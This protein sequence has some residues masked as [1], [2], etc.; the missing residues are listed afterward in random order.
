METIMRAF[1]D[2]V[3]SF[4]SSS[5]LKDCGENA[6]IFFQ[7]FPL[8]FYNAVNEYGI[9]HFS[10]EWDGKYPDAREH[11]GA[12]LLPLFINSAGRRWGFYEDLI[13]LAEIL[14][15][16]S[17]FKGEIIIVKNDLFDEYYPI[18]LCF[19]RQTLIYSIENESL[20]Q[21]DL[22][23]LHFYSDC[24][25]EGNCLMVSYVNR[26]F[27]VDIGVNTTEI[28]FY[29]C[30]SEMISVSDE[31]MVGT[32]ELAISV[33]PEIKCALQAGEIR[34]KNYNILCDDSGSIRKN[35]RILNIFGAY[36]G[37][38]FSIA[39][40]TKKDGETSSE[41]LGILKKYWGKDADFRFC[42]FY[43]NPATSCDTVSIS[44]GTI[45]TDIVNQCKNAMSGSDSHYS[46]II[47]TAPT[48]AGKSIFFQLPAIYLHEQSAINAV[49][50]V[51]CPL[52]ALM[53]DQVKELNER[54]INY[55]TYI[56]SALTYEERQSRLEGIKAG[57][58]SI[59]YL[60]P[61][62][63]LAYDIRSLIGDRRIGLMAI[64][65]AHLVTSWGRDFRVD[66]WFLGDYIEKIRKGSF[67][68]RQT[69]VSF[70]VLCLTATAVFGGRDDIIGDLQNSLHLTCYSEHMYIGY[71][72]R[73]N[74]QFVIRHPV[75]ERKSD[76]EEKLHMTSSAICKYVDGKK[77][78]IVYFPYKSQIEDVRTK[79]MSEHPAVLSKTE[80]YYSGE[81]KSLEK[82]EAYSNFRKTKSFVMM[83][84]KAFGMG[85]N[86][87]DV[88]NVYHYA[89]T[90][91]LADYVQ[92]IGRAA[93]QL[94]TG[95]A[96]IDYLKSDMRYAQTLWGL[97]G[98]RHYQIKAMMKK[99]YAL[100]TE[101][102]HRNMLFSPET[103]SF[104]FDVQSV[105]LKVKSGL[106]LLSS[107]LLEKY[108]FKVITVRAK[109]LFSKQY[110]VVPYSIE[111]AFL[112]KYGKYCERMNDCRKQV[113]LAHGYKA[114]MTITKT[115]DV[116]EI[117][118][119]QLWE[120]EFIDLT[121]AQF[122][123]KFFSGELFSVDKSDDTDIIVPNMKLIITYDKGYDEIS[124]SFMALA[125]AIQDTFSDIKRS[126]GGRAF[127]SNDFV[128][129]FK[130]R[131]TKEIRREYILMLLELFCY[132]HVDVYDLPSEPW[133][134]VERRKMET[135]R[136]IE[137]TAFF[138]R[139]QKYAYIAQNLRR[140]FKQAAPNSED[141]KKYIAYISL[142]KNGV[143]PSYQQLM[144][145]V[146]QLFD[147]A[148]YEFVGGRNPQIFVRIN[149][150]IKLRRLAES[151][152]E[153]RNSV[154]SDI[155]ARHKRAVQIM[156]H[157]MGADY[158]NEER[159]HIIENY[160]LGND[161]LVDE[162]LGINPSL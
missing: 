52:V 22:K 129:R 122:K 91:T 126:F 130:K 121:F 100:Y 85:V 143:A 101:K 51:V 116:Y 27:S 93:R 37:V 137:D 64:D 30:I 88:V 15:D 67:Y 43:K 54:G 69:E 102:R 94:E 118:L 108:H 31:K 89:P 99:L 76:K 84:T 141:G 114:E 111:K 106:M 60:S 1:S 157:F 81:M 138:I 42:T 4:F 72:R 50:L 136:Q 32:V 145:S 66:Y 103:F 16:F 58:Y 34:D 120:T 110:I 28:G 74:I 150:P 147:F 158:S 38:H 117:D 87:G 75:R 7:G 80:K 124:D 65:E 26:H 142:P 113:E 105:D 68:S 77:K 109:N 53:V 39:Y 5:R 10:G 140:Y 92:E 162:V 48:G 151:T 133:K 20:N 57:R 70:P 13:A 161:E 115:G 125:S 119:A 23:L 132:D 56:N 46:D 154:L 90:G 41:Y 123:A 156:N 17:V 127:T 148:T 78:T 135:E 12:K 131:Y 71:V 36:F 40:K 86:I 79:L 21:S 61:E 149:D 95:Y 112:S 160:F 11:S 107:D 25:I 139:T 159:W 44:Q 45:I 49:T 55:A 6:I 144:A 3:K 47:V 33:L 9:S 153:Y 82:D 152:K 155:E 59:I 2:C 62:L 19:D 98:L 63:L 96:V 18:P 73:D 35:I 134:F 14:N 8:P 128:Q 24:R 104:L 83:A 146:L 29:D 97:S